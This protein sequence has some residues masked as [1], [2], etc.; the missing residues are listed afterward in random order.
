MDSREKLICSLRHGPGPVPVDFGSTAVT[1]IHVSIVAAL[2]EH[3]GLERRP[4]K[5]SEP[6][7]MLGA[8]EDDLADALGVD[9]V[10][11]EPPKTLFGFPNERWKE[12]RAPWGQELL[13]AGDFNVTAD[14]DDVLLYPEGDTSAPA[15]GRMPSGGFFFDTIVRQ[16]PFDEDSLDPEANL[17]EFGPISDADLAY[18]EAEA[19]R[20]AASGRGVIANF[21]GTAFG[22][23]AL[24]PAPF[25]KRPRGVRDIAEWYMT[26]VARPDYVHAIFSRQLEIALGNLER[27]HAAVG[28]RVDAVFLCGTDFGTQKGTF[29]SP[30]TFDE[31]WL[32]YYKPMNDWIH[33]NTGW[34]TFKH[35]CGAV[36]AFMERFIA[37]GFDILNPVQCSAAGMDPGELKERHGD[38]LV[39]W[40]GGV[41]TQRTLPFG[42]PAEVRAEVLDRCEV[43]SKDGGFVFNSVH[44]VQARTPVEN[45]VAMIDA[46]KEFNGRT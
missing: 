7:Q 36:G 33:A 31:L 17:E 38:R 40:G 39:F 34:K 4:V 24:V 37:A 11:I 3:Y 23:I 15:S 22:D 20:A 45:V 8:V 21:G 46:V 12:W 42:S 19:S 6:Y 30:E 43:F 41:D 1:G 27:I 14:G 13:V 9:T 25:M 28:D 26:T 2:R 16:E 5:A 29:C 44:N 18:F 32:P 10:G 35:S